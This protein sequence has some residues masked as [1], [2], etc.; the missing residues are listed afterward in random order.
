MIS[1]SNLLK[2]L[3]PNIY[4]DWDDELN[5]GRD[6]NKITVGSSKFLIDWKCKI[7]SHTY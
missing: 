3:Y 2:V 4:N 6:K 7:K 5:K 1:K